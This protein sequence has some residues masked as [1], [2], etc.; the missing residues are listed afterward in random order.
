MKIKL[1]KNHIKFYGVHFNGCDKNG[2]TFLI[3]N[4]TNSS[5]IKRLIVLKANLNKADGDGKPPLFHAIKTQSKKTIDLLFEQKNIDL[6]WIDPDN[7]NTYFHYLIIYNLMYYIESLNFL[8]EKSGKGSF[9]LKKNKN[10]ERIYDLP[11]VK[12]IF[13]TNE[14]DKIF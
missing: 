1:I 13:W 14:K 2:Q 9:A 5:I 11:S 8:C 7:G 3:Q 6:F 4:I 12:C 10:E